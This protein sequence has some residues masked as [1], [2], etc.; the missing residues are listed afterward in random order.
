MG[1]LFDKIYNYFSDEKIPLSRKLKIIILGMLVVVLVD[2]HYGFTH[3]IISSYKVD[4]ITKL[5]S[6]QKQF[7]DDTL[8]VKKINSL[9]KVEFKRKGVVEK[10]Y[11]ILRLRIGSHNE[12]VE[13]IDNI[14]DILYYR[15][16]N[17]RNPGLH[18]LTSALVPLMLMISSI[19]ALIISLLNPKK[20]NFDMFFWAVI[21]IVI[22][23]TITYYASLFWASFDPICGKIWLNYIVQMITNIFIL[24]FIIIIIT[25]YEPKNKYLNKLKE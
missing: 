17:E 16:I 10:L 22:G 7:S 2:N 4:Y 15:I 5:E 25:K 13:R 12:Q 19:M 8:F 9:I 1:K 11:T 3:T 14:Y 18:T 20:R 21:L 6:A 23:G 24:A